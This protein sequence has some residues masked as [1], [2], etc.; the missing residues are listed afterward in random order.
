VEVNPGEEAVS[1]NVGWTVEKFVAE[2]KKEERACEEGKA[3][4]IVP[5]G[6]EVRTEEGFKT[7]EEKEKVNSL[8]RDA[9]EFQINS[10]ICLCIGA[11]SGKR[12][13]VSFNYWFCCI[14]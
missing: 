1:V 8:N 6:E 2:E 5:K 3:C 7:S 10:K 9:S 13:Q 14:I 4:D 11:C 12:S